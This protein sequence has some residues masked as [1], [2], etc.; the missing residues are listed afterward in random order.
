MEVV[1]AV[2]VFNWLFSEKVTPHFTQQYVWD[3]LESTVLKTNR[4]HDQSIKQLAET[5]EKLKKVRLT[6]TFRNFVVRAIGLLFYWSRTSSETTACNGSLHADIFLGHSVCLNTKVMRINWQ[7][8][9]KCLKMSC[10]QP[11]E[12]SE[13][14]QTFP[15][16]TNNVC[17]K[18][19][20]SLYRTKA[21]VSLVG[22]SSTYISIVSLRW[23]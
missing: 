22:C 14:A 9:V 5:N 11:H 4:S 10:Y 6:L 15:Q 13:W 12:N 23:K 2:A 7:Y 8:C 1:D 17:I 16:A 3:I 20:S 18:R 21:W 19:T